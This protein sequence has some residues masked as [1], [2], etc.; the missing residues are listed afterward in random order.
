MR[1]TLSLRSPNEVVMGG[2][3]R[4][5]AIPPKTT[6][7]HRLFSVF[8]GDQVILTVSQW[9]MG[10]EPCGF[11]MQLNCCQPASGDPKKPD[12]I[13]VPATGSTGGQ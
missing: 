13:W 4:D 11:A 7:T 10:Q 8:V 1:W 2:T 12:P 6:G 3:W 9:I 5:I